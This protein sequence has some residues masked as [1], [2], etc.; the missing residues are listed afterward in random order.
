MP[1]SC[2][3]ASR[4]RRQ[5]AETRWA[6][7]RGA[8]KHAKSCKLRSFEH[9]TPSPSLPLT[10]PL[11]AL[12]PPTPHSRPLVDFLRSKSSHL[13]HF[14]P[15]PSFLFVSSSRDRTLFLFPS[16][17]SSFPHFLS[18]PL[19]PSSPSRSSRASLLRSAAS[20]PLLSLLSPNHPVDLA[21]A[22]ASVKNVSTIVCRGV[23]SFIF[24]EGVE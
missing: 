7:R 16:H 2:R 13:S 21:R 11:P 1:Y 9:P 5:T 18:L 4:K 20:T 23:C 15:A 8:L 19:R 17:L 6:Q 10:L 3:K 12:P 24:A 22:R 14:L